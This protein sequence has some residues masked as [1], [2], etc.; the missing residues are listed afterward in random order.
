M[1]AANLLIEANNLQ[2]FYG[3][4]AA[5]K[6]VDLELKAG[7]VL[8]LLG[9]N[10]AGKSTILQMLS[11]TLAP[12]AGTI[13]INGIDLK[14]Q[15]T[16]ARKQIGY[17]PETPPLYRDMTIREYLNYCGKLHGLKGNALKDA[18]ELAIDDCELGSFRNA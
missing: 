10:G 3:N 17:L 4:N 15:P 5:V 2:R 8:G 6:G 12:H 18:V 14:E 1:Q 11:G 7:E 13:L 9:P 16:E